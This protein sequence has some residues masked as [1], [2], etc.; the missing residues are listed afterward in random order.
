MN[1]Q[2]WLDAAKAA[3]IIEFEIY[4]QGSTTTSIRLF[5]GSVDGFTISECNGIALRGVYNGKMGTY[6]LEEDNDDVMEY[7]IAQVKQNASIITS[8][9][10]VALYNGGD[11]EY[12]HLQMRENNMIEV[13]VDDKIDLLKQIEKEVRTSDKRISQV[14]STKYGQVEL[15]RAIDNTLGIHV[16]D[17][18]YASFISCGVMAKDD[19]DVKTAGD[20]M[21][22]YD[23]KD[24][25]VQRFA[26]NLSDKVLA[27]LYADTL[28]SGNYP[29]LIQN[30]AMSDLFA[31]VCEM[32]DGEAAS[33]GISILKQK[34]EEQVFSSC[35]NIID[36]PLMKD[37][38]NSAAFD[39][40]GVACYKKYIVKEGI[41]K[42]YLHNLKSANLMH[43]KSTGNGFKGG[44]AS[45]VGIQP[46]NF[47]IEQG[48]ISYEDMIKSM[49]KGVIIT[50]IT[51][52]HAGVNP[53]STEFSIQSNGFY[54]ENGS[55]VRP[56]NLITIAGNFMDA[57][58]HIKA[59]GSDLKMSS[60]GIGAPSILF[61]KMAISGK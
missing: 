2:V 34:I 57:M 60:N 12:P 15:Y 5:E 18:Q 38:Y 54:V 32:F 11:C 41:L 46:T 22:L 44:Y 42:T 9:D 19:E 47:Y 28:E 55:I 24:I 4:E 56:V 16:A 43:T 30:E 45:S 6:F 10:S 51:G 8:T 7:A 14:M 26:K 27:K 37:G 49:V 36:D 23:R 25:D 50:D 17:K 61:D 33:K 52:L 20:W 21:Y 3:G 59:L 58:M 29:V 31:T 53:I 48:T 35:I 39:D 13:S 1:K 40:E